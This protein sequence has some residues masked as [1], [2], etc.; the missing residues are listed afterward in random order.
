MKF[1]LPFRFRFYAY[2]SAD[3]DAWDALRESVPEAVARHASEMGPLR[4]FLVPERPHTL[5]HAGDV[6]DVID[7]ARA[8]IARC[9]RPLIPWW[10]QGR[11]D[12]RLETWSPERREEWRQIGPG[13]HCS[14]TSGRRAHFGHAYIALG[15]GDD[16]R[17]VTLALAC[18][19]V[20]LWAS[21]EHALPRSW[22]YRREV[23][24]HL[25]SGGVWLKLWSDD[26]GWAQDPRWR[27]LHWFPLDTLLGPTEHRSVVLSRH[28]VDLDL[29]EGRYTLD[30]T[31]TQDE[32]W[33][34][35]WP[36]P[37]LRVRR[38]D[39]TPRV[40]VPVPGKGENSWDCGD[41][42][43]FGMT[44]QAATVQEALDAFT[45]SVVTTRRRYGGPSWRPAAPDVI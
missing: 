37:W 36:L 43:I 41:T 21:I 14:W 42:A 9:Y 20:A 1:R 25:H 22:R 38:A 19:P 29:P 5:P 39:I 23:G 26:S 30:V 27:A 31:L 24:V 34:K 7:H 3:A 44:A 11:A 13:L 45:V 12:L 10:V 18:P 2:N 8:M 40:P 4:R 6:R 17:E 32:W 33:R 28:V 35:R 15:D 16:E